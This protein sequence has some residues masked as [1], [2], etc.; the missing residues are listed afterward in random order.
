M[1]VIYKRLDEIKVTREDRQ[2]SDV[3]DVRELAE[4]MRRLGLIHPITV[5]R[6]NELVAGERRVLAARELG[7]ESIAAC[8]LE[9]L[10]EEDR[11]LVEL[12]ENIRRKD[13]SWQDR[14][15]AVCTIAD[16]LTKDHEMSHKKMGEYMGR[17]ASS[18][19]HHLQIGRAIAG[20]HQDLSKIGSMTTALNVL[21]RRTKR[22]LSAVV[23]DFMDHTIGEAVESKP[24]TRAEVIHMPFEDWLST[25]TGPRFNL[26]H[27]DFP[28]G[29]DH[30]RSAQG[31]ADHWNAFDDKAGVYQHLCNLFCLWRNKILAESCHI[32]FWFSMNH[33]T[34]TLAFFNEHMP[35]VYWNPFPLIWHKTDNVGILPDSN[36]GPRRVYETA[37]LGTKGDRLVTR[38]AMNCVGLPTSK[39]D[40]QHLSEKPDSV[41]RH[42]FAML[43][44]ENTRML[45]P[46]CGAGSALRVALG[47][48]AEHVVGLE[49]D[50][51]M[52]DLSRQNLPRE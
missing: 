22:K 7:W 23:E 12:E 42:F 11:L 8:I 49:I 38:A 25:Y 4:S 19:G 40:A 28:F 6:E 48:G 18:L 30:Q 31:A 21:E 1:K 37:L 34:D 2:R 44:D 29:I 47:F 24:T 39:R 20:D 3:S 32:M 43:V 41:L 10:P 26:I 9:D 13:I 52:A 33:Y 35:E 36:R 51:D 17:S 16:I 15:A 46:T 14:C 5:T 50:K 27:C 45:D